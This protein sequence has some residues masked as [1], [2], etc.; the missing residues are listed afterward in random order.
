MAVKRKLL[1]LALLMSA[2]LLSGCLYPGEKEERKKIPGEDQILSVQQ[3]VEK[4]REEEGGILPIKNQ[5]AETDMYMKY[6]IDFKRLVPKYLSDIPANAFENGGYYQYVIID[7]E[8]NPTVKVFDLRI[9]E[10]IRDIKIRLAAKKYP[11]YKDRLA[12]DVFTLDYKKLGYDKEP[13][14][15]SPFTMRELSLV[16]TGDGSICVDYLPDLEKILAEKK[17]LSLKPG[18][19]IRYVLTLDSPFVPAYSLPYTV[20][21][22]GRPVFKE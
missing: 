10:T 8:K 18:Q 9:A 14:V 13:K 16:I 15:T 1:F 12:K 7:P 19:D 3:A 17:G 2:F 11:P 21:E 5:E 6:P 20:D 4:F 22:N